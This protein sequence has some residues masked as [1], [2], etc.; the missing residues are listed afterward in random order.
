MSANSKL[1]LNTINEPKIAIY[2][3]VSTNKQSNNTSRDT[4]MNIINSYIAS[5]KD[6]VNPICYEYF[7]SY[8][9]S[10]PPSIT[11]SLKNTSYSSLKR[12]K[13]RELFLDAHIG[14]FDYVLCASHDRLTR[15]TKEGI[16]LKHILAKLN[17]QLIYCRAGESINSENDSLNK[18]FENL[19]VNIAALESN[20]IGSRVTLASK[21]KIQN[22]FWAGGP[23]PFGY[24]LVSYLGSKK[25]S[26]LEINFS[27]ARIVIK[28]F[29][30]YT[31][32]YSYK[33]ILN[34]LKTEEV[35]PLNRVWTTNTLKE[36]IKNPVYLGILVWNK[37]GGA[38]N[39]I[40]HSPKDFVKSNVVEKNIIIPEKK[41]LESEELRKLL[42]NDPK[43]LSTNFLLRDF[44]YCGTCGS[45][46]S[47][48][49]HGKEKRFYYC[50]NRHPKEKNKKYG[51]HHISIKS[52]K[53]ESLVLEKLN[54][55]I[56]NSF[57]NDLVLKKF[58]D[59]Y[60][61]NF[62]S[63]Q[64]SNK[65]SLELLLSN[66]K[67]E[68]KVLES[69]KNEI[70]DLKEE[71]V[72]DYENLELHSSQLNL[73]NT[74][75]EL[76]VFTKNNISNLEKNIENLENQ[77]SISPNTYDEFRDNFKSS[78]NLFRYNPEE[79]KL[80]SNSRTFRLFLS[81]VIQKIVL[82]EDNTILIN[83]K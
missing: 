74:L 54:E 28:I 6:W 5:R 7:E 2:L 61:I 32:G 18:F 82:S 40:R 10:K 58:Y 29:E 46:L 8:S 69:C 76:K 62:N 77:I 45:K 72:V 23:P 11:G 35:L 24:K 53:I 27:E 15:N 56:K 44:I 3:R 16:I 26:I 30:L 19:L 31:L 78:I 57:N 68:N 66:L 65:K 73:I 38:K 49:N 60:I 33:D 70:N 36:I 1:S 34:K 64:D 4:Q 55:L 59:N 47:T 43:F 14:K 20:I 52:S 22:N 12:P 9:A 67:E 42:S 21:Y 75:N 25:N 71:I 51:K 81:K 41:F 48:K 37:R 39:P 63:L 17:I 50:S 79:K 80:I 83:F 13:L